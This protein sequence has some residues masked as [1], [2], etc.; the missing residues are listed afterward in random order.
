MK[1]V[2]YLIS[3]LFVALFFLLFTAS[4]SVNATEPTPVTPPAQVTGLKQKDAGTTSIS[5][6]WTSQ[7]GNDIDY[8]VQISQDGKNWV[9]QGKAYNSNELIYNCSFAWMHCVRDSLA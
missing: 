2:K 8:H 1:K 7:L 3:T 6:E 5:I 9:D 4:V